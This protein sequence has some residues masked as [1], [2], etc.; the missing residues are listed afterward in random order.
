MGTVWGGD[1]PLGSLWLVE[2]DVEAVR[3]LDGWYFAGYQGFWGKDHRLGSLWVVEGDVEA[4]RLEG[5]E[6]DHPEI[7]SFLKIIG[8]LLGSY[9]LCSSIV[10]LE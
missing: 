7:L 8:S 9:G 3:A 5:V 4:V 1:H 6:L 2:G 10:R